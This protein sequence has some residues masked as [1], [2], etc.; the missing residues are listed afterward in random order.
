MT[1]LF[2]VLRENNHL[3]R[4]VNRLSFCLLS[5][6]RWSVFAGGGG[7]IQLRKSSL[8]KQNIKHR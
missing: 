1:N 2:N 4:G 5:W 6:G 3:V 8:L 7:I